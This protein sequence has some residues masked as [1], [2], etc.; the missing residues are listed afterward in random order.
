M[1]L[2]RSLRR[3]YLRRRDRARQRREDALRRGDA[4]AAQSAL[5]TMRR[6]TAKAQWA[7]KKLRAKRE[8]D[9]QGRGPRAAL[10]WAK[11]HLFVTE[12]P[13]GSNGGPGISTWQ[14]EFGFGRVPWCGIFC[15][16]ALRAAGVSVT[17]R[18]ASVALIEADAR[19][20]RAPFKGWTSW[21]NAKPGDLAVIGGHGVHVEL[22]RSVGNGGINTY[23]G[24]TSAGTAGSQ[25][26]GGGSFPRFRPAGAVTGIAQVK[27]P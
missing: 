23:G 22:V 3:L 14:Q 11:A 2:Y 5:R 24:N 19:A 1:K 4:K 25:S 9:Q 21:Q 10:G 16:K 7:L 15:G 18:V 12:K 26:N 6:Y 17:S 8:Q 27:Y 20:H 13:A